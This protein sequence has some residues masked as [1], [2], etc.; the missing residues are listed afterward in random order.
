MEGDQELRVPQA[1][2]VDDNIIKTQECVEKTMTCEE[3]Q[4]GNQE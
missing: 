2:I 1:E 4:V 3:I